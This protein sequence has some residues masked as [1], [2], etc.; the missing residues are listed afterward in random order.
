MDCVNFLVHLS[1]HRE[2]AGKIE[3]PFTVRYDPYT[4]GVEVLSSVEEMVTMISGLK[5]DLGFLA[6]ALVKIQALE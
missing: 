2:Y 5:D 1:I 6:L 3:R 4:Q